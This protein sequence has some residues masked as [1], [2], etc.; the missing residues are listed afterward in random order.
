[1]F[2]LWIANYFPEFNHA[3]S[4]LEFGNSMFHILHPA[5]VPFLLA[6]LVSGRKVLPLVWD[7]L[8]A[9][10]AK[11]LRAQKGTSPSVLSLEAEKG[12]VE[13]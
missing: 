9:L 4:D 11:F 6:H 7:T 1:M 2:N 3:N 8:Y 10:T 13:C 5:C 12:Q